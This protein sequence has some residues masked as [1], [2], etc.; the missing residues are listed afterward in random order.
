MHNWSYG[1]CRIRTSSDP[2]FNDDFP[3]LVEAGSTATYDVDTSKSEVEANPA[4]YRF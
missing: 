2:D 4:G 1:S 3:P